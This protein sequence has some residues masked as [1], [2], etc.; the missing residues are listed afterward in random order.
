MC[1]TFKA[2]NKVSSL[3]KLIKDI[4]DIELLLRLADEIEKDEQIFE[5][6]KDNDPFK[7]MN[8]TDKCRVITYQNGSHYLEEMKW[9]ITFDKN[10]KSPLIFNSRDDTIRSREFW[11][12]LFDKNRILI[13]AAGFY[14]W[15][16]VPGK[17]KKDKKTITVP[18]SELIFFP[19]LF[20]KG[21]DGPEF[22]MITTS[23]NDFMQ[24]IH[25]RMPVIINN[26]PADYFTDEAEEN[27][28]KLGPYKGAMETE[29]DE[30][31]LTLF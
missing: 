27:F 17:K 16:A 23:P 22:T 11:W 7:D 5:D 29:D 26:K 9:G 10:A 24:K 31:I 21:D 3:R 6:E 18:G 8:L 28:L 30:E 25:D 12:E 4:Y 13:P 19:G 14:E 2:I 1:K 15:K 20:Y